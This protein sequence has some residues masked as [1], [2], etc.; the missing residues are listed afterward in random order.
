[1]EPGLFTCEGIVLGRHQSGEHYWRLEVF[2]RERGQAVAMVRRPSPRRPQTAPPDLF[3]HVVLELE[4]SRRGKG[5]F[6]R[7]ARTESPYAAIGSRYEIL[8]EASA[9]AQTIWKNL[10]HA[11]FFEEIFALTERSLAAFA[12]GIRPDVTHFKSLYLFAR[13]EGY[14]VKEQMLELWSEPD[15]RLAERI[16][17]QP[18]GGEQPP[19]AEVQRLLDR[20]RH[21][22]KA[23]TDILT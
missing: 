12:A 5:L 2:S 11:E 16:L 19:E 4:Q 23:Y 8:R 10:T 15:R 9:F 3:Q 18:V 1:M 7:E 14:P 13:L 22:L 21:Y 20:V 6:V 17:G